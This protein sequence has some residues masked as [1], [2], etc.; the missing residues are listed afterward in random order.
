MKAKRELDLEKAKKVEE[1]KRKEVLFYLFS[2]Y[3]LLFIHSFA[4]FIH[5][6]HKNSKNHAS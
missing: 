5:T 3:L 1:E 4:E 2:I 6:H